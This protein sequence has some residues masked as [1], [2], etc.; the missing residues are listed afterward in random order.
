MAAIAWRSDMLVNLTN[1]PEPCDALARD[2][3][4]TNRDK[5]ELRLLA[6]VSHL[7][8]L[9]L[10]RGMMLLRVTTNVHIGPAEHLRLPTLE[11]D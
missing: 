8:S 10:R 6:L 1:K 5:V 11:R 3:P 7:F 4:R 9:R 2:V